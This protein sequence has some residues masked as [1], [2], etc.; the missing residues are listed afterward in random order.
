MG[1]ITG[2]VA[3]RG[4]NTVAAMVEA[5]MDSM[6]HT[7]KKMGTVR[8]A[9]YTRADRTAIGHEVKVQYIASITI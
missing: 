4:G 3:D 2:D 9:N 6:G 7:N 1:T 5:D 8:T